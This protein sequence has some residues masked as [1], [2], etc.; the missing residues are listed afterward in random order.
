MNE[1]NYPKQRLT[2]AEYRD[3][4]H[5]VRIIDYNNQTDEVQVQFLNL[6]HLDLYLKKKWLPAEDVNPIY[7]K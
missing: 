5:D 6:E 1:E 4:L 2:T 7:F 3:Q